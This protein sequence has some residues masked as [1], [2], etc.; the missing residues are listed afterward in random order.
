MKPF[1]PLEKLILFDSESPYIAW[2]ANV[3]SVTFMRDEQQFVCVSRTEAHA[4]AGEHREVRAR[5]IQTYSDAL[6]A[7]CQDWIE[8]KRVLA[9]DFNQLRD[10]EI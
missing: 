6:W 1:T 7:K 4:Q 2:V 10:G 8:R 9:E 3:I 5:H